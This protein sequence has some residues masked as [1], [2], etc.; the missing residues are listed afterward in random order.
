[1]S[2]KSRL[3]LDRLSQMTLCD[4]KLRERPSGFLWTILNPLA[5]YAVLYGVFSRWFQ[6][7]G[8]RYPC[9]LLIGILQYGFFSTAT[10]QGMTSVL[11]RQNLILNFLLPKELV[12][13]SACLGIALS[14]ALELSLMLAVLPW[15]GARLSAAWALL[16]LLFAIETAL[17]V[18]LS[19]ALAAAAARRRSVVRAWN[20]A[21][22]LGFFATPVFYSLDRMS[23]ERRA[24]AQ[25]N[26]VAQIIEMSRGCLIA[27]T[28]PG[29]VPLACLAAFAALALAGG[30]ALF[31]ARA[32]ALADDLLS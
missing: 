4:W 15:L 3:Y 9:L 28:A 2:P 30:Y 25:F 29:A 23:P 7:S 27:G 19:L 16:P 31:N 18:G 5:T 26:P 20:L 11:R 21:L 6:G 17:V 14:H 22:H 10:S 32:A 12:V 1:V 13:L 24:L 8:N